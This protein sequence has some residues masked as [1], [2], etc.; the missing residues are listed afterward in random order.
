MTDFVGGAWP[1]EAVR[2]MTG[3]LVGAYGYGP[4]AALW[5]SDRHWEDASDIDGQHG[6]S[7]PELVALVRAVLP[8][9]GN[10]PLRYS[11]DGCL[12]VFD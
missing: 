4:G 10:G 2:S 7:R 5:L 1:R 11:M 9:V 6:H 8:H 3:C 12:L